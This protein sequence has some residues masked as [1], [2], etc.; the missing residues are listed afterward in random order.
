MPL[1]APPAGH[2][3]LHSYRFLFRA[4]VFALPSVI[5]TISADRRDNQ[6]TV[7]IPALASSVIVPGS[8]LLAAERFSLTE[9]TIRER[10]AAV[11]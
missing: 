1:A 6:A 8:G 5:A 3:Q 2:Q 4:A 9:Q 11:D 7:V 10:P